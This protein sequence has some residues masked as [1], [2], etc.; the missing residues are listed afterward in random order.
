[1]RRHWIA[2]VC[3]LL[4]GPAV[5]SDV[6][7]PWWGHPESG[8]EI[9]N[10]WWGDTGDDVVT[11]LSGFDDTLPEAPEPLAAADVALA[12]AAAP[13]EGATDPAATSEE[14][15]AGE[16]LDG[17]EPLPGDMELEGTGAA[18][19]DLEAVPAQKLDDEDE[20][21]RCRRYVKQIARFEGELEI[22]KERKNEVWQKV[23]EDHLE[24]LKARKEVHCPVPKGPS[25]LAETIRMLGVAAKVA[26]KMYTWGAF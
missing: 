15:D 1:M 19:E 8:A 13:A 25:L 14:G 10:Q 11:V 26:A 17:S 4:A 24:R 18:P 23:T 9:D 22:A 2:L 20:G 7:E 16:P 3:V 21:N 6:E 5:A 12:A